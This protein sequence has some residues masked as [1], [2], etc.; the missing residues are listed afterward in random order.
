MKNCKS[1]IKLRGIICVIFCALMVCATC[2]TIAIAAYNGGNNVPEL[3]VFATNLSFNDSIYIKYAIGYNNIHNLNDVKLLVWTSPSDTYTKNTES[4]ILSPVG[5]KT[6]EGTKCIIFDYK[7]IPAKKLTD[8]IYARAYCTVNGQEYYSEVKKYSALTYAYN[9]LGYTGTA[10]NNEDLK[11][12]LSGLLEYGASAQN[13]FDYKTDALATDKHV[14]VT[15]KNGTFEDG[16]NTEIAKVGSKLTVFAPES[17]NNGAF[18][19]WIDESGKIISFDKSFELS[20]GLSNMQ[21]SA[22]YASYKGGQID[23]AGA[24]LDTDSFANTEHVIDEANMIDVSAD[25]LSAMLSSGSLEKRVY[26]VS[27]GAELSIPKSFSGNNAVI[28]APAGVSINNCNGISI[29]DVIIVG[30]VSINNSE[31]VSISSTE[32][33]GSSTALKISELCLNVTVDNCRLISDSIALY[34]RSVN[35]S[36]INSYVKSDIA[37][38]SRA[39]ELTVYNCQLLSQTL[40]ISSSGEDTAINNNDI[41]SSTPS[42]GIKIHAGSLNTLVSYNNISGPAKAISVL[43]STNTVVILNS[44]YCVSAEN[45][46]NTYVVENSLGGNLILTNNNYL[47]CDANSYFGDGNHVPAMTGN[48]NVNGDS[49]TDV[50]ARNDVGAN[51]DILPHTNKELFLDMKKKETVK[52]VANGTSLP[53]DTFIEQN[54]K[55]NG[56]VIVPPGAYTTPAGDPMSIDSSMSN[57]QIYAFGVY[58]EHGFNNNAEYLAKKGGNQ[59]LRFTGA[60][61][62]TFHGITMGYDYQASGQV[63]VLAKLEGVD[64]YNKVT[65]DNYILVVPAAGYDLEAGFGQSNKDVFHHSYTTKFSAGNLYSGLGG[66]S[67][68]YVKTNADGTIVLKLGSDS[69]YEEMNVGDILTCRM[70]G[71]NQNTVSLSN[72]V[73]VKLKDMVLYGYSAAL[74]IVVSGETYDCSIERIHNL[75]RAPYIIDKET[76]DMYAAWEEEYDVDL[77]IY[78]D[79]LGRYRGAQPRVGSVDATHMS[80]SS[81]GLDITSCLFENMCDDGSNQHGTSYRLLDAKDNGDGT[82]TLYYKGM[83]TSTYF[84]LHSASDNKVRSLTPIGF[85][86]GDRIYVYTSKG[87][88]VCDTTTLEASKNE[89]DLVEIYDL[90][91]MRYIINVK[92]VKV[93]TDEVNFA[94]L[95]GYDLTDNHYDM[96]NKVIVDNIDHCSEGFTIDNL[97]VRNSTARG[98]LIKTINSTVKNSTFRNVTSTGNLLSIES[99]WGESTVSR[100]IVISNCLFDNTGF[101]TEDPIRAPIAISGLSTYGNANVDTLR[102]HNIL[103]TGCEFREYGHNFGIYVNGA[104][105]VRIIDNV[106]D[107]EDAAD[108]GNFIK[109]LTAIDIEISGN[110]YRDSNGNLSSITN[111]DA[112]DYTFIHGTDVGDEFE[113]ACDIYVGN[114]HLSKMRVFPADDSYLDVARLAAVKLGDHCGYAVSASNFYDENIIKL[115][116]KDLHDQTVN[117]NSYTITCDGKDLVITAASKSALIYAV[118]DFVN[119]VK[120]LNKESQTI[121]F[122][123]GYS[124]TRTF[125]LNSIPATDTSKL[126]YTGFWNA[127]GTAMK[128]VSDADYVEMDIMGSSITLLFSKKAEF[129]LSIDGGNATSHTVDS[130]LTLYLAE[131]EHTIKIIAKDTDKTVNF[132]GVKY[133]NAVLT[134]TP[135][136]EHYIQFIGDSM[137]DSADSFAHKIGNVLDWDYSVLVGNT[138][139]TST[140][141]TGRTPDVF[142]IFLGTDAI[143]SNSSATEI[144]SFKASYKSLIESIIAKYPN[145][146]KIYLMQALSTSDAGNMF[147]TSHNRYSAIEA[148]KSFT[149]NSSNDNYAIA[150]NNKVQ[151][152]SAN[153][154][155]NWGI[156]FDTSVDTTNPTA[157]GKK[158]LLIKLSNYIATD[159][160][161]S[162]YVNVTFPIDKMKNYNGTWTKNVVEDGITFSRYNFDKNGHVFI[163]GSDYADIVANSGR[164][165]VIKYRTSGDYSLSLNVRTND[166]GTNVAESGKGYVST[167]TKPTVYVPTDWEIAV[168][169]LSQF[170]HYT[171]GIDTKVQIRFTTSLTEI[172]IAHVSVVDNLKEARLLIMS[173]FNAYD[174]YMYEDWKQKGVKTSIEGEEIEEEDKD[175]EIDLSFVNHNFRLESMQMYNGATGQITAPTK[176][177][178][179]DDYGIRYNRFE[180]TQTGHIFFKGGNYLTSI[181]GDTGNYLVLKYRAKANTSLRLEMQTSD[182]PY[183]SSRPY[184]TM[185]TKAKPA[186]KITESWEVAVIDL[187]AFPNFQRDSDLDILIRIT[188]SC[189]YVDISYFA[190]VDDISEAERYVSAMG[191]STY[192]QYSDWS[193]DGIA[194]IIE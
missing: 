194:K 172:D 179:T 47:L 92:S 89:D 26:R 178:F 190:L 189:E 114:T 10:S 183:N 79:E 86:E 184:E 182:L 18:T 61:N 165:L 85:S 55:T 58:N 137:V 38:D 3:D 42:T 25:E 103:I 120:E 39:D 116:V 43:E 150:S 29:K 6:V 167:V 140:T 64:A 166:Y 110:K 60:E 34:N 128:S 193:Q 83:V 68:T 28:I 153:T 16:F 93:P 30:D 87:E 82:T 174:Y 32:I 14:K 136:K 59:I 121:R 84:G 5:T 163:S 21:I 158:T 23:G 155:I 1:K 135:D 41:Y 15:L 157:S 46:T 168:V 122:D 4:V 13:Y 19:Y 49:I 96:T 125:A 98:V 72:T 129:Y 139:P 88:L 97:M 177:L 22:V 90:T 181:E 152:I 48:K 132:A 131:G 154:V 164:Y 149:V 8:Y 102:T 57:T 138:L 161:S 36:L 80:G 45:N 95:E 133:L 65:N 99:S 67:Y 54:A 101:N 159:I 124:V 106:F 31:N 130:E 27:N 94:A 33:R 191:D 112:E 144:S 186:T 147:N 77:E 126:K 145:Y 37:V 100:N 56:I 175:E 123:N 2:V 185:S 117:S 17:T 111:I 148:M 40:G 24:S 134:R 69:I 104:Q 50:N 115:V 44:C 76:Y 156:Q 176:L 160:D 70:A 173:E 180:F 20:V 107:P 7:N 52:D 188:T 74:M 127:S 11:A 75:A 91:P 151:L 63:H 169:D 71:D 9:K 171:T 113:A 146:K 143:T 12:L 170:N 78:Q 35:T 53:L 66:S 141:N 187:A 118:E 109:I 108:P 192:V 62:V 105:D 51:E 162:D 142:V 119:Y 81:E 73:N